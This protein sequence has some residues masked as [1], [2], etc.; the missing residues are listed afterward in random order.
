MWH[1]AAS[2]NAALGIRSVAEETGSR[3]QRYG[4]VMQKCRRYVSDRDWQV[5]DG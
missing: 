3:G 1:G 5:R 4:I 2:N